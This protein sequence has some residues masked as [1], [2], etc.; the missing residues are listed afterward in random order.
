MTPTG[1]LGGAPF[2]T[3]VLDSFVNR[4]ESNPATY[5]AGSRNVPTAFAGETSNGIRASFN[6]PS[7]PYFNPGALFSQAGGSG[8]QPVL[9]GSPSGLGPLVLPPRVGGQGDSGQPGPVEQGP[10]PAV[11]V[12]PQRLLREAHA[13]RPGARAPEHLRP[14][15]GTLLFECNS[16]VSFFSIAEL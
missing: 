10:A 11:P 4:L 5:S 12:E 9:G 1:G 15:A 2:L 3:Q 8:L 6:L 14:R 16:A 13:D 7:P